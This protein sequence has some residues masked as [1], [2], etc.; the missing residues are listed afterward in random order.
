[1][2]AERRCSFVDKE[3]SGQLTPSRL[4]AVDADLSIDIGSDRVSVRGDGSRVVLEVPG[5]L[6]AMRIMRDLGSAKQRRQRLSVVAG[7]LSQVGLT[8]VVRSHNRQL[9]TI[10]YE[11]N[12]WWLRLLGVS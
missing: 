3:W 1:M 8:V 5:L 12:S 2:E 9:A 11:G 6:A 10:G 7:F 4:L